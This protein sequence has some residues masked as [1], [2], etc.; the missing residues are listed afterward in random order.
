MADEIVLAADDDE[1]QREVLA[2]LLQGAGYVPHT[3]ASGDALLSSPMLAKASCILTDMRMP[4]TD[5]MALL[6]KLAARGQ[7]LPVIV[8]T[9]HGDVSGAVR[10]M[11]AGA[12]D[13]MEKPIEKNAFLESVK[14]AVE[15]DTRA[16][17]VPDIVQDVRQGFAQLTARER[18]ILAM[19]VSGKQ[20]K[21]IAYDLHI[22][23][24]TVET[25]RASLMS[26]MKARGPAHLIRMALLLDAGL[27]AAMPTQSLPA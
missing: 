7:R 27:L 6:G 18:E 20:N 14:A 13:F 17:Q 11:R 16:R 5:G 4:G 15:L 26:K 3:F 23:P 22:S 21:I 19:I 1:T 12:F 8:I 25:H 9:A 2:S 10:A 24:R